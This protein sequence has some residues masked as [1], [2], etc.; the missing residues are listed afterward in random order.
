MVGHSGHRIYE[1]IVAEG[2]LIDSNTMSGIM[3]GIVELDGEFEVLELDIGRSNEDTSALT[4][5]VFGRDAE[6]IAEIMRML[7]GLGAIPLHLEDATLAPA[8]ADGVFPP[9]F[10]STTNLETLVRIATSRRP[11]ACRFRRC[12]RVTCSWWARAA[13]AC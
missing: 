8:P 13:C 2:H 9:D 11:R 4:M 12:A 3:R 10:Y 6:H 7:H 1:D 5:R